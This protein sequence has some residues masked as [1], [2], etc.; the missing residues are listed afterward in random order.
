MKEPVASGCSPEQEVILSA[1]R[2]GR[3]WEDRLRESLRRELDW[4]ILSRTAGVHGVLPFLYARL[5]E[6]AQDLGPQAEMVRWK[7]LYQANARRNLVMTARLLKVLKMFEAHGIRAVPYKGPA[8]AETAYGDV[9]LRTFC[10]LDI[11]VREQDIPKVKERLRAGGFR[12]RY[13]F[14]KRQ[15][16]AH[17]KR[18][19]EYT[20]EAGN[21]EFLLDVHWRLAARYMLGKE[22]GGV[23]DRLGAGRLGGG[24]VSRLSDEDTLLMLCLHG[25]F[26]LWTRL[27]LVCDVA[28]FLEAREGMDGRELLRRAEESGLRRALLLG[29]GLARDLLDAQLPGGIGEEVDKDRAVGTLRAHVRSSLFRREAGSPGFL[30]TGWFQ[31][32][33]KDRFADKAGYVLIRAL[34]PTV[35]DWIRLPLPDSLYFL[36]F[37]FRPL[38]LLGMGA[39]F[40]EHPQD[41]RAVLC[42]APPKPLNRDVPANSR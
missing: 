1:L 10:D 38:R 40:P 29:L 22:I 27:G 18:T 23:W 31:W 42:A 6:A 14:T 21:G 41:R 33:A 11:L 20:F 17:R 26:H 32:K 34:L 25:T 24:K 4:D 5:K 15:E 13:V 37:L 28:R 2:V 12:Q 30:E 7:G 8:L 3:G 36:Y 35:E 19:C 16:K 39:L 9:A